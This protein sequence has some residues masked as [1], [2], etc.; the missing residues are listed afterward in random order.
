MRMALFRTTLTLGSSQ[1][2]GQY[3]LF[4]IMA[5]MVVELSFFLSLPSVCVVLPRAPS[6]SPGGAGPVWSDAR[7]PAGQMEA[8][9]SDVFRNLQRGQCAR[10]CCMHKGTKGTKRQNKTFS[11]NPAIEFL[12]KVAFAFLNGAFYE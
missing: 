10:L 11:L 12:E 7:D 1:Y 5:V 3:V 8:A 6:C 4:L 9:T 2:R